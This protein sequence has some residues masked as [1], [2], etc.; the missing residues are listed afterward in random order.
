MLRKVEACICVLVFLLSWSVSV[1]ILG[2]SDKKHKKILILFTLIFVFG[3][4]TKLVRL[5]TPKDFYFD[6][7]YHAYTAR[8]YLHGDKAAY[9]PYAKAPQ[10]MAVEWTHPPLSKLIMAGMMGVFGENS[11]GWRMGSVLFGTGAIV[12]TAALAYTLFHSTTIALLAML[13]MSLETLVM[14]QSRIAMNDSYFVFFMLC[15]LLSY[16]RFKR[17]PSRL[18]PLYLTGIA[19]GLSIA[20]KWT[21]LYVFAIIGL[22]LARDIVWKGRWPKGASFLHMVVALSVVPAVLYIASYTQFFLLGWGWDDLGKLQSQMWHYHNNLSATHSYSSKPWQWLLNIR[23]VWMYVDYS[24]PQKIGNIYNLGNTVILYTGLFAVLMTLFR[25]KTSSWEKW[26]V[27]LIYFALWVPWI[28]SPRIMLFYHYMPAI[29][30]LCIVLARWL[31]QRRTI[32][33]AVL[34][35]AFIWFVLFYPHITAIRVPKAFAEAIY[36][37]IASLR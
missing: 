11:V 3:L 16:V 6:E 12:A 9:D 25:D 14:A 35:G 2:M 28:I 24:N 17:E 13:L 23:P 10:G 21:A 19:L 4:A 26:F 20:T 18:A 8:L 27:L 7:V 32:A 37:P 29:P 36:F 22:D 15:A 34:A 33:K 5:G 30:A 31:E 1:K